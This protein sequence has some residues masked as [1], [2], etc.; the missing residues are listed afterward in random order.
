[1]EQLLSV[2]FGDLLTAFQGHLL[3]PDVQLLLQTFAL[4]ELIWRTLRFCW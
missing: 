3:A 2:I 4:I 1:M